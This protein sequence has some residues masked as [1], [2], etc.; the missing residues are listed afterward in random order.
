LPPLALP[1]VPVSSS[2]LLAPLP[3]K[4][5]PPPLLLP[6][7]GDASVED[8]GVGLLLLPPLVPRAVGRTNGVL[9]C[10]TGPSRGS[11]M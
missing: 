5:L 4:P 6:R 3:P 7:A 11:C 2:L 8:A 10:A 9:Y 1:L